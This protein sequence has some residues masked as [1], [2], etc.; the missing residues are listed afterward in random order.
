MVNDSAEIY[1]EFHL[2]VMSIWL[3]VFWRLLRAIP[4]LS[5][6][7]LPTSLRYIHQISPSIL[8]YL[9]SVIIHFFHHRCF[10]LHRSYKC[11]VLI[12]TCQEHWH[13][14]TSMR[15]VFSMVYN[16]DEKMSQLSKNTIYFDSGKS[17]TPLG[18]GR[19]KWKWK[20]DSRRVHKFLISNVL[21]FPS[22]PV[23]ILSIME[24]T[25]FLND[26][27]GT[28]IDTKCLHSCFIGIRIHLYACLLIYHQIYLKCRLMMVF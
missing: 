20:D 27:H 26:D 2:I 4:F 16:I 23:N 6:N 24:F 21:Y 3:L 19:I 10:Q 11:L 13:G 14:F 22:S 9:V 28:G 17:S 7:I 25:S 8:N 1:H 18:I 15:M 12:H 5:S